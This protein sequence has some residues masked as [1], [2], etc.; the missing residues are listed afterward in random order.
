M[1]DL[2]QA[3][4]KKLKCFTLTRLLPALSLARI[5]TEGI[6]WKKKWTK[7]IVVLKKNYYIHT[8]KYLL[9]SYS[10]ICVILL[11][12]FEDWSDWKIKIEFTYYNLNCP[13]IFTENIFVILFAGNSVSRLTFVS[14]REG[15]SHEWTRDYKFHKLE[16]ILREIISPLFSYLC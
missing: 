12:L 9:G 1:Y 11:K 7:E 3:R 10:T 8:R 6:W 5:H 15:F 2:N 16:N 13:K 4:N 14:M